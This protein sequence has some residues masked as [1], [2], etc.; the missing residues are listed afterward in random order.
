MKMM[1]VAFILLFGLIGCSKSPPHSSGVATWDEVRALADAFVMKGNSEAVFSHT[2]WARV[3]PKT[4]EDLRA[5]LHDWPGV[6]R[7]LQH[8]GTKIMTFVEYEMAQR[9]REDDFTKKMR[10]AFSSSNKWNV[11]PEKII[12][13]TYVSKDPSKPN[14]VVRWDVGV[15]QTNGLWFFAVGYIE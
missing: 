15:F 6:S 5:A 9:E 12:E 3:P 7:D 8:T 2:E 4:A 10:E 1:T 14:G 11:K 13:Y